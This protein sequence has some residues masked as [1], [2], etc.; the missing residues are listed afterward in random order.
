MLSIIGGYMGWLYV[1]YGGFNMKLISMG[2]ACM[3]F[4]G[5]KGNRT[6]SSWLMF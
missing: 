2:S 1:K 4:D 3:C 5:D 6:Q